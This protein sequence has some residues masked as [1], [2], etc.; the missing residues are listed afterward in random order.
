MLLAGD[1]GGT[2]ALMGLIEA[3]AVDGRQA[4]DGVGTFADHLDIGCL[5]EEGPQFFARRGF[6]VDDQGGQHG[7]SSS[8]AGRRMA[9]RVHCSG[10]QL[11]LMP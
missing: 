9:T 3:Q 4:L 6:V 8:S 5:G 7:T 10:S 11:T 2:K 1:I